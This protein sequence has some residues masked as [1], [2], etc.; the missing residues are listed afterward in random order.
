MLDGYISKVQR[1]ST[2]DGPGVRSTVFALGCNLQCLWCANPELIGDNTKIL[3]HPSRCVKCGSCVTK[4][5]GGIILTKDGIR[6]DRNAVD[7]EKIS[8]YC[9]YDAYEKIGVKISSSDLAGQLMRDKAFF[10]QSGGGVT[11][12]GGEAAIQADFFKEVTA[13]L[14]KSDVHVALDTA[15]HL[16]W[17]KLAPLVHDVDLILYDIKALNSSLHKRYTGVDNKL[18]L[19]NAAKIANTGKPMIVRMILIPGVN[20]TDDEIIGRLTFVKQLN[21]NIQV[22]FLKYHKLGSEKYKNLGMTEVMESS[23]ECSEA[24]AN[25]ALNIALNMGIPATIGG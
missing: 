9:Y 12:S 2:K 14:K 18:I 16:P 13:H 10:D 4:S 6:I 7:L 19:E 23:E 24:L 22:D 15:G 3:H 5:D 21:A 8:S 20:D 11:Y 17:S 1:Y 25:Y